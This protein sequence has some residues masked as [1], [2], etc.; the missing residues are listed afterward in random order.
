[1]NHLKN[2]RKRAPRLLLC[3]VSMGTVLLSCMAN[4]TSYTVKHLGDGQSIVKLETPRKYIL[5]PV[6]EKS[7]Q[8]WINV[9][10][11][12]KVEQGMDVRLAVDKID[13]YVPIDISA[14][15]G[16]Q[17]V[18]NVHRIAE[19]AIC[20]DQL[21]FADEFDLSNREYYRP[22]YHFS[23]PYGWMNDPNGM[24]YKDGEYHLFYQHNP[25]GSMWGNMHW[26]HA[27]SKDLISWEHQPV[28]LAP[29]G[30][31]TIFSGC[32][33][34]DKD[35]TAGF[36][37]G[38]I[39]AFYTSASERQTQSM[40]YSLDNGRSFTKF[41]RNPVVTSTIRDFRDPKVFWHSPTDKWIMILAA[42][43]E[44][45]LYS[46]PD[47]KEWTYESS[48]GQDQGAHGGV[49][50]CPDLIELPV[51]GTNEKKWVLICNLNPGGPFGGSATQYFTGTFD[52]QKF[53]NESP[54]TTKWMD[55]G[56]DHYAAVTWSN[57]PDNRTI[58]IAWMSNWQ[59]ANEVPTQQFRSANS[60]PRDLSLYVAGGETYIRVTPS[61]ELTALR[62]EQKKHS[63]KV[64]RTHNIN[65]L[66][67]ANTGAYELEINITNRDAE[68]IGFQLFN[69]KGEELNCYYNLTEKNF[70]MDRTKS[71]K[72][73]FSTE[74]P[75]V[76]VAPVINGKELKLRLFLDIASIEAFGNDGEFAMTNLIF[77]S[78]PYNR[79]SFYTKGG[80]YTVSS[81]IIYPLN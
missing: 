65:N 1:M 37:A 28:A 59:Y 27:T 2:F 63:F 21:K 45:Q 77:P 40:A 72:T 30:L 61:N 54:A 76:T 16:K 55:W 68:V 9:I 15:A 18:L 19:T 62:G 66:L 79:I 33:V 47:L 78:E 80:S 38:A 26:G 3:I 73:D 8:S 43:Q 22:Q 14:Y 23:P 5:L 20:W 49:W 4:N 41:D 25:Y 6:Q 74:F 67:N 34:V 36:G 51:E 13:Y 10:V 71:G 70:Y 64:E 52:G 57:A 39:V 81:F 46:S 50:E 58:A 44:M 48:F 24:V 75:A 56:K 11:K 12:N 17:V 69:T 32:A 35:N 53:T 42:S 60:V 29:D 31:G 7:E